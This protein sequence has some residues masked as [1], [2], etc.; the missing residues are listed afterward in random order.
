MHINFSHWQGDELQRAYTFRYSETPAPTQK[1]DCIE[2]AVNPA[3]REGYD[4]ISLISRETYSAGV[5]AGIRCS[6]EGLGCPEIILV[7]SPETCP[8]GAMRYGACFE[9]VLYKNGV[10][11]WRHY[12][13]ADHHC[14]WHKRVGVEFPVSENEI[15]ELRV[16]TKE[17]Y[18]IFSVDGRRTTLRVEDLFPRFHVGVTM[19][20]GIARIYEMNIEQ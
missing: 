3:H 11:V 10:N 19:C 14:S 1:S 17:N 15:H 2:N 20:E 18:L 7:E 9:V 8:D 12:M 13:N 5:S 6:F 16:E 4:N